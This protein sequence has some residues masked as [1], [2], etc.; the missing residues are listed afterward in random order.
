VANERRLAAHDTAI[1]RGTVIGSALG[2]YPAA[3]RSGSF[4][5][6]AIE[7]K[8]SKYRHEFGKGAIEGVAAPSRE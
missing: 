8:V 7:K 5:A 2:Y 3:A 4:G 6:Y 1:L